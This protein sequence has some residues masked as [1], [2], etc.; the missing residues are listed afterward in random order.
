MLCV[1]LLYLLPAAVECLNLEVV[2]HYPSKDSAVD[3]CNF[4]FQVYT[5]M[6]DPTQSWQ[7]VPIAE[8]TYVASVELP[9]SSLYTEGEVSVMADFTNAFSDRCQEAC[10]RISVQ[11]LAVMLGAFPRVG[12]LKPDN[13]VHLWPSFCKMEWDNFNLTFHSEAIYKDVALVAR[14][15]GAFAENP[16]PR[17]AEMMPPVMFRLNSEWYWPHNDKIYNT[18]HDLM[19]AGHLENFVIAEV[20][21]EGL[22]WKSWGDQPIFTIDPL[23]QSCSAHGK[24]LCDAETQFVCD[25]WQGKAYK[26]YLPAPN[27]SFGTAGLF[28]DELYDRG[29]PGV[30]AHLPERTDKGLLRVGAWGYCIGGLGAWSAMLARPGRFNLG[31]LGSPAVD[32]DCGETL[33]GA[34]EYDVGASPVRPKIY[35]DSGAAEGMV[36]N[37]MATLLFLKLKNRGLTEGVDIFYERAPFGTHQGRSLQ[38]RAYEG[39]FALFGVRQHALPGFEPNS[40]LAPLPT[41]PPSAAQPSALPGGLRCTAAMLFS[42]ATMFFL[43]RR[44]VGVAK[45][46]GREPLL[47]A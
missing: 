47:G 23:T 33:R 8:D 14:V 18:W 15:P 6:S 34:D 25:S 20:W 27:H 32:F 35:I 12:P 38:R 44:S 10:P 21:V 43:G 17:P 37:R 31:Y 29:L 16:L 28:Y 45:A 5:S 26:E 3:H 24:S 9:D 40:M 11:G 13:R 1:W 19:V 41:M 30:L 39:V 7:A 46:A 36:M 42:C 4:T 2:V 22:T